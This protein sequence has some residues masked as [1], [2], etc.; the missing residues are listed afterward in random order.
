MFTDILQQ[1]LATQC[2]SIPG[3]HSGVVTLSAQGS[4]KST[5]V[6]WP[7][8]RSGFKPLLSAAKAVLEHHK[9]IIQ[10]PRRSEDRGFMP[11]VVA[12]PIRVEGLP[13]GAASLSLNGDGTEQGKAALKTLNAAI[14]ALGQ[15]F[16]TEGTPKTRVPELEIVTGLLATALMHKRF[17]ASVTALATELA[18]LLACDRVSIGM[19]QIERTCL[20]GISHNAEIKPRQ[21]LIRGLSTV[22]DEALD[23]AA[24][25]QFPQN[26]SKAPRITLAHQEFA[27]Q[28]NTGVIFTV[29]LFFVQEPVGALLL[30]R[31]AD[32][33]FTQHTVELCEH[34]ASFLAPVLQMKFKEDQPWPKRWLLTVLNLKSSLLSRETITAKI[35]L[36]ILIAGVTLASL[37]LSIFK[38]S[39]P[40]QLEG[41]IQRMVTAPN[42]GYI[43]M[44]HARPGDH[45]S[46]GQILIELEDRDLRLQQRELQGELAQFESAYGTALANRDRIRLTVASAEIE[47]TTAQLAL[48]EQKLARIQLRAPFDSIIILGDLSQTLGAPVK[49]G[50]K[51]M[52]LAPVGDYRVVFDVDERDIGF[53]EKGQSGYL[54]LSSNPSQRHRVQISR[55]MP[56]ATVKEGRNTFVAEA[57]IS[58]AASISLR[59]GLKG[60]VKVEVEPRSPLWVVL[61]RSWG[62]LRFKLWSWTGW[63]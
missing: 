52:T 43:K 25:I 13:M 59:P 37:P 54:V 62:W 36:V 29:P 17:K 50:E 19:R 61:H 9:P 31:P 57:K 47:K 14:P 45:V 44:I 63:G 2:A 55:I 3:A 28:F 10:V 41:A 24:S 56:M 15:L 23:Q 5:I 39:A 48:V 40:A 35:I 11:T 51:L 26:A 34:L 8:N 58:D 22:M 30:E 6:C 20:V 18:G 60:I 53:L 12:A 1:W 38:I 7:E 16:K 46:A 21:D 33:P 32:K 42:D 27:D 49:R 4:Q